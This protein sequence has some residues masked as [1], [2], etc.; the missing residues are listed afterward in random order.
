M[1]LIIQGPAGSLP[2][3][4]LALALGL[5]IGVERG[6]AART[7]PTGA[8]V[9]GIRTFGLVGLIGGVAGLATGFEAPG[10][11]IVL[12]VSTAAALLL[13]YREQMRRGG[14]LSSTASL[15]GL[16]TLGFGYLATTGQGPIA[17][18]L[19]AV[20][21]LVLSSRKQLHSWVG[22]LSEQEVGAIARFALISLAILPFL[23]D[24]AYGP[25]DAWNPRQ[26]WMV[27]VLVSGVSFIGYAINKHVGAVRG[28]LATAAA[29]AMVSSTAVTTALAIRLRD[30]SDNPA[31][32]TS[33]IAVASAVMFVRVMILTALLAPVALPSLAASAGPAALVSLLCAALFFARS[34]QA[35]A[36][37]QD[38][39][40]VR[41]PFDLRA[42]LVLMVL[43]MVLTAACRWVLNVAG[44][45]GALTA[46]AISGIADVDSAI[47]TLGDLPSGAIEPFSAGVA[48]TIGTM[49]NSLFKGAVTI[50]I[51]R[52]H[53]ARPAAMCL[54]ASVVVG[55]ATLAAS[56][57]LL[58][59]TSGSEAGLGSPPALRR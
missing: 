58:S 14:G 8:R 23:P 1:D 22:G 24:R 11:A 10:V 2:R 55:V 3:L 50:G 40:A 29:G 43:V 15:V 16:L 21:T 20:T 49:L 12:L 28:I 26:L 5:L 44:E 42:A 53:A 17:G 6:W 52:W 18:A 34:R 59:G 32:L 48:L 33:G 46:L 51:A 38:A 9:A 7:E 35:T 27:V 30:G 36:V 39:I 19:A 47:I 4:A 41:N 57:G 54:A 37:P 45:A 31:L 13:G 56:A 25:L